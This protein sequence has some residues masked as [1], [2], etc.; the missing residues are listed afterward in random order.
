[1]CRVGTFREEILYFLGEDQAHLSEIF[2]EIL[3]RP[4]HSSVQCL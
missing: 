2:R 4:S 1:M 3:L